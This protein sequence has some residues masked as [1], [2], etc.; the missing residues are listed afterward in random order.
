KRR[1][2]PFS[3]TLG[4]GKFRSGA[5]SLGPEFARPIV[6]RGAA[7]GDLDNDGDLDVVITT[8]H[9]PAYVF[10]NDGGNRNHWLRVRTVGTKSSRDGLGAGVRV[11]SAGGKQGTMVRSGSSY[12]S[13][14]Q[15]APTFGLGADKLVQ[16]L[17]V[18]WPSGVKQRFNNLPVDQV[19][20]VDEG[21]G[22]VPSAAPPPVKTAR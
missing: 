4:R 12:C 21:K 19:V 7:Y 16:T 2:P 6:A 3:R 9:G 14:S 11:T 1:R 10:R 8:N 22:I 5:P 18:E 17:E 20:T 15:M 13:Q